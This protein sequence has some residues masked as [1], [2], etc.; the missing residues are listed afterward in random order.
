MKLARHF[1]RL[2]TVNITIIDSSRQDKETR[3]QFWKFG[4]HFYSRILKDIV[5]ALMVKCD[6]NRYRGD[7]F[8]TVRFVVD[9]ANGA[10]VSSTQWRKFM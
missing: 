7:H 4:I 6:G 8:V 2:A 3:D 5:Q 9:C 10:R 1:F